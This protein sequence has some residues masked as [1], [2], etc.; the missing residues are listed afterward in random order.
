[1]YSTE[2]ITEKEL[3]DLAYCPFAAWLLAYLRL[4]N[5]APKEEFSIPTYYRKLYHWKTYEWYIAIQELLRKNYIA[6]T[7]TG[8]NGKG[9]YNLYA[10]VKPEG[11]DA[12]SE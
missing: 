11:D 5:P 7:H 3:L 4:K 9:D 10:W 12:D 1:M 2:F 6:Q 8:G